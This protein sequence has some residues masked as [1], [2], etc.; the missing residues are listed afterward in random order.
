MLGL[1][2]CQ[3]ISRILTFDISRGYL[4]LSIP[5][6]VMSMSSQNTLLSNIKCSKLDNFNE[7]SVKTRSN[8]GL[9]LTSLTTCYANQLMTLKFQKY[10]HT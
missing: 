5:K 4:Q 8:S 3:E 2:I 9:L 1:L 6:Y 10:Q 7:V